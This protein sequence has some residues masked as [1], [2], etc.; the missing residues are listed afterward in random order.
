MTDSLEPAR[1][2]RPAR[3]TAAASRRT[4][5]TGLFTRAD[6]RATGWSDDAI[7]H[8][9]K[10]GR[11]TRVAPGLYV[12][13]GGTEPTS[14][15]RAQAAART[16][17]RAV[18]SHAAA[19]ELHGLPTLIEP[20]RPC[21]TVPAGTALR[22]L[23]NVHLHR[24]GLDKVEVRQ[25]GGARAT[26]VPRRVADVAR[27]HGIDAGVVVADAALRLGLARAAD[28][29]Q[30]VDRCH[31]WPGSAAARRMSQLMDGRAESVLESVSRVR[32]AD[33]QLPPV[34][35]QVG[36]GDEWGRFV[37]RADFYWPQ[38][39]VI[40]EADGNLKYDEGR[41]AIVAERR[42]QQ[43]LED[44]GLV[45]VRWEWSDLTRF[46]VVVRRLRAAF[47]RGVPPGH[48]QRWSLL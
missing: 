10:A 40:G 42:R 1:S 4:Q 23:E 43:R 34:H 17:E 48:G 25:I 26:A 28:L 6:A 24:A 2:V 37:A 38:F 3:R 35:L 14:L 9:V 16:C 32:I 11:W 7:G 8:A 21:L 12:E 13:A 31:G 45:V 22:C 46:E 44:L 30:A 5:P 36:I 19:A 20:D 33:A 29:G 15:L 41:A 27:E 39:G 47:A 18:I